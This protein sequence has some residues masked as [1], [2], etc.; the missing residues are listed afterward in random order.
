MAKI[1]KSMWTE[2]VRIVVSSVISILTT[3]GILG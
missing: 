1:N 3:L 2:I